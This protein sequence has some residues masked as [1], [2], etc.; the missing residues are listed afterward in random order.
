MLIATNGKNPEYHLVEKQT[1]QV[2][3]YFLNP[4]LYSELVKA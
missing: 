1:S 3:R 4:N 2:K